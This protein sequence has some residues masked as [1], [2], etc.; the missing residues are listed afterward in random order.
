MEREGMRDVQ[1]VPER[2]KGGMA[3]T[4][5]FKPVH[6]FMLRVTFEHIGHG[7]ARNG[8]TEMYINRN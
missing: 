1:A 7:D 6:A 8:I 5:R 3:N 4:L 2:P